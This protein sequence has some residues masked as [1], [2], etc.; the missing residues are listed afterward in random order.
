GHED[1]IHAERITT[2]YVFGRKYDAWDVR[3]TKRRWWVITS[4]TNLYSQELF[5][6]LDYTISFHVGFMARVMSR[7]RTG[8]E[9]MEE[10][11]LAGA[12]RKWHQASE[13]LDEAE[14]PEDFQ[15][16]GMRC[17]ESFVAM[18]RKLAKPE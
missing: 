13:A 16:V 7:S 3:T 18:A 14:E 5:S 17:R 6:S 15:A 10:L 4:P 11:Q 9:P 1:V 2:E 8:V 12:W